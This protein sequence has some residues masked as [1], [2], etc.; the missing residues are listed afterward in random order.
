MK[1]TSFG[2]TAPQ[3]E[4]AAPAAKHQLPSSASTAP[5]PEKAELRSRD[6]V[7][8]EEGWGTG[9]CIF[10]N[11]LDNTRVAGPKNKALASSVGRT[12]WSASLFIRRFFCLPAPS[13]FPLPAT[14][15]PSGTCL[16]NC[17]PSTLWL[18]HACSLKVFLDPLWPPLRADDIYPT[19]HS[20][21]IMAILTPVGVV[22][23]TCHSM[24]WELRKN[25]TNSFISPCP[26]LIG[27]YWPLGLHRA[28]EI[29]RDP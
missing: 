12:G 23:P 15:F 4:A 26:N 17:L 14:S 16:E 10:H 6:P 27:L 29:F 9:N 25:C 28:W 22:L 7:N 13:A 19:P 11:L 3:P 21:S 5:S 20:H 18:G 8:M 24:A 2:T 1:K